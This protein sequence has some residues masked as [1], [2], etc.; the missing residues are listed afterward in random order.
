MV[1]TALPFLQP[2]VSTQ[3]ELFHANSWACKWLCLELRLNKEIH[4]GQKAQPLPSHIQI[5]VHRH[6]TQTGFT[7]LQFVEVKH[8]W[9]IDITMSRE[10]VMWLL[11]SPQRMGLWWL[12][13][14]IHYLLRGSLLRGRKG[15]YEATSASS[16]GENPVVTALGHKAIILRFS[17]EDGVIN[18][19]ALHSLPSPKRRF[20]P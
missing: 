1:P 13:V 2:K 14:P 19:T 4:F 5:Y 8:Y 3:G 11:G 18:A 7:E 17:P 10:I 12:C 20:L 15:R 9:D 16:S 6:I